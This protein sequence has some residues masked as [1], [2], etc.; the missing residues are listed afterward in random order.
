MPRPVHERLREL[1]TDVR[2]L[3]VAPAAAVRARGR[4]RGRRQMAAAVAATAV[5]AVTAGVAFLRPQGGTA[6]TAGT[7]HTLNCVVTLPDS[8]AE[9]HVRVLDGGAPAGLVDTAVSELRARD[10]TV[11]T[12]T[13]NQEPEGPAALRYGPATIGAASLLRAV[14]TGDVTM[15]FDPELR[16][17]TVDLT[18]G[19]SFERLATTTEINQNLV[20]L[21]RPSAPPQCAGG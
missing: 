13:I 20:E 4:T 19:P 16:G 21:G 18:L 5:V 6:P 15:T 11:L 2:D 17:E 10:V 9:V 3:P 12:G 1:E 7:G 8:F 14:V